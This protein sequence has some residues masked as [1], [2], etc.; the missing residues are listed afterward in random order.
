MS[1]TTTIVP[2]AFT[3]TQKT[4]TQ[5]ATSSQTITV[6]TTQSITQ[7][8]TITA[9]ITA[10]TTTAAA[11]SL[12]STSTTPNPSCTIPT[13][14]Y[15]IAIVNGGC[16][17]STTGGTTLDADHNTMLESVNGQTGTDC[18]SFAFVDNGQAVVSEA[19]PGGGPTTSQTLLSAQ[20]SRFIGDSPIFFD[21]GNYAQGH[22]GYDVPV[23]FCQNADATL[24]VRSMLAGAAAPAVANVMQSCTDNGD[25]FVNEVWL[26]NGGNASTSA[27]QT[28][29][30]QLVN[31]PP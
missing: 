22:A 8:Q 26:F 20:N 3:L 21:S 23:T 19:Q 28:V 11:C 18:T 27:C 31:I 24:V 1:V 25:A 6:T 13:G 30:L 12:T 7:T 16:L 2:A 29:T 5:T 9:T 15:Y 4:A 17:T 14:N 10:T